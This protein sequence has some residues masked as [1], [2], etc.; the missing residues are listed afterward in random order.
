MLAKRANEIIGQIGSFVD[1]AA[2]GA[3]IAPLA[4]GL[5]F[6]LDVLLIVRVGH[7]LKIAHH[8]CFGNGAD[9]HP[10]CVEIDILLYFKG[11]ETVD[12]TG[13]KYQSVV[14]AENIL[15]R[16]FVHISAA[17]ETESLKNGE[18]RIHGQTVDV[19]FSR[20]LDDVVRIV[21]LVDGHGDAVRRVRHLRDGVDDQTVVT[22]TV[23]RSQHTDR[24][25]V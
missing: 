5:G 14:G 21:V 18:R 17:L 4:L 23:V 8:A 16:E 20:G 13:Q 9:E 22:P 1:I 11:K 6:R 10:V 2:N 3:D 12:I 7:R 25:R 19:H 15:T 24:N